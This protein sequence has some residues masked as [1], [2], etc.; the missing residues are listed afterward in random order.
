MDGNLIMVSII[1]TSL[2]VQSASAVQKFV[3]KIDVKGRATHVTAT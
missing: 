2:S 3:E 1:S